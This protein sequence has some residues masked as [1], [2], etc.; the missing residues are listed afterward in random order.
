M[1]TGGVSKRSEAIHDGIVDLLRL[2]TGTQREVIAV[3]IHFC[4]AETVSRKERRGRRAEVGGHNPRKKMRLN[5]ER[6]G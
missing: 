2:T 5:E 6:I 3:Q 1:V 4:T